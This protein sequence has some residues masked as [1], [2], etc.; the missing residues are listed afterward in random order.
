MSQAALPEPPDDEEESLDDSRMSFIDHLNELRRR[1]MW[2]VLV[3]LAA[4]LLTFSLREELFAWIT[5]PLAHISD[6]KMQVLGL[7][8]MFVTYL[9]LAV[10]SAIFVSAPFLLTQMWLFIAPGLYSHEKKW[11]VPFVVMGTVFF[12]GGGAFGFY[13]VLPLG[14]EQLVLMVPEAIEANFRVADYIDL[15]VRMLLAFGIVFELPLVMWLLA[16]AGVAG[17]ATFAKVRKYWLV[18]AFIIGALLTPPDPIT[19]TMM[20]IPLVLFFE[21]GQLGARMLY[22]KHEES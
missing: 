13:V 3:V 16:A 8:E 19:Q 9:K 6:K 14:F 18:A 22:K 21:I 5:S 11:L 2:S 17:P 20:A 4:T 1:L 10:L 12:V 7:V 15:V